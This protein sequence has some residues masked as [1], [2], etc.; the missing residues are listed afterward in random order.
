MIR[1]I[2]DLPGD[3][4]CCELDADPLAHLVRA[5]RDKRGFSFTNYHPKVGHNAEL[6]AAANAQGFT[7][8]LVAD[9]LTEADELLRWQVAPVVIKVPED[10]PPT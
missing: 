1:L 5:N 8:N 9:S 3:Q 7:I 6:I 4:L 2:C 10:A